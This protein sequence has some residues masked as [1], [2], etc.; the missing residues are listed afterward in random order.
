MHA[1]NGFIK[2]FPGEGK[3][4]VEAAYSHPFGMNEFEYGSLE[5]NTLN[6]EATE[7]TCF[8]RSQSGNKGE[9][10]KKVTGIWR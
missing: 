10:E 5:G 3:K 1:E 7:E 2:V 8:H 6:L 9:E 4:T